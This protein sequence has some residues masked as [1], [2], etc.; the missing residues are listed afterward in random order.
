[1]IHFNGTLF[2]TVYYLYFIF[3]HVFVQCQVLLKLIFRLKSTFFKVLICTTWICVIWRSLLTN[4]II[5]V[6]TQRTIIWN[7]N[8]LLLLDKYLEQVFCFKLTILKY[9]V[10]SHYQIPD[11]WLWQIGFF[12][13]FDL[14]RSLT[15]F[16]WP[17]R[18]FSLS[19]D[20]VSIM[21][22]RLSS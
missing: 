19:D 1:M 13:A 3:Q 5:N 7:L 11:K 16:T 2:S 6:V 9:I 18:N 17:I 21:R 14:S 8:I 12:K 10:Q 15:L 4:Q 22:H 20:T